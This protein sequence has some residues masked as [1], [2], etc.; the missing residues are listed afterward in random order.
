[1]RDLTEQEQI[2]LESHRVARL[3]TVDEQ[4][5]PYV[6]PICYAFDGA[7]V[8]S[9]LDE[10]PKSVVPTQLKRVRNLAVNPR[11]SVVVDDYDEDWRRLAYL[12]LRGRAGLVLPGTEEHTQAVLFLR[13]KYPQYQTMAIEQQPVLRIA[14]E[15][16][17]SW[18]AV[19]SQ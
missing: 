6:V 1:M 8:Y 16:C 3:A 10:K 2:F 9:A 12:Q 18:G 15:A 7:F 13:A 19:F 11:V 5:Q 17:L 14:P 4:K